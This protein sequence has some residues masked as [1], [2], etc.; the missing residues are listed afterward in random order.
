MDFKKIL[1]GAILGFS[2]LAFQNIVDAHG[3][4]WY[5]RNVEITSLGKAMLFPLSNAST[6][7][8][9]FMNPNES[10]LEYREN[11]Y[12]FNQF[13]KNIKKLKFY[14]MAPGLFESQQ[15][16]VDKYSDLLK[17][18]SSEKERAAAVY[19]TTAADLYLVP[20]FKE[21]RVQ[22]DISPRMEFDVQ[23]K[24]WTEV[25]NAPGHYHKTYKKDEKSWTVHHVIPE[26][27]VYLHIMVMQFTGYDDKANKVLTF[28]DNRRGY[29][30]SEESQFRNIV[31]YFRDEFGDVKSG[32]KFKEKGKSKGLSIGFKNIGVPSN[33]GN[34]EYNLKAAFFAMKDEAFKRLKGISIKYDSSVSDSATYHVDG[35]ISNCS[36][37]SKWVLPTYSVLDKLIKTET[38][39]WKDRDNKEHTQRTS[40]YTQEISN[41]LAGWIFWW[42][43]GANLQLVDSKT[44]RVLISRYYSDTDDKLMDCYRHIF[45]DFYSDVNKFVKNQRKQR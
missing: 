44:N 42:S 14:R 2:S 16:T 11:D 33:V 40:Y 38:E 26:T 28:A 36:L 21:K 43:V 3:A 31:K 15:I 10:S 12:L 7:Y 17:S 5:D 24:S 25:W 19:D 29:N 1:C 37:K 8:D 23:L 4:F 22:K 30:T 35:A 34:D 9:Y 6:P 41:S 45:K 20:T 32:K 13:S 18:F 39:K 27:P